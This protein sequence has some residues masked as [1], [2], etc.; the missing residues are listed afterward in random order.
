MPLNPGSPASSASIAGSIAV[1]FD[2]ATPS[3]AATFSG[4]IAA[5]PTSGSGSPLFD[6][7]ADAVRVLIS[8]SHAAASLQIKGI[9]ETIGVHL[10]STGGTIRIGDIPGS[11]A[12][13]F[14]PS[15]PAVAATF[16]GTLAA[17]PTTGSGDPIYEETGNWTR[18]LIAGS[19]SAA[20]LAINGTLT[21][22]TNSIAVVPFTG[23]GSTLYD[24]GADAMRVLISGSHSAASL[25]I[26]G[27]LT[28]ITNSIAI[29]M[30]STNGTMA[31]NVGKVD[32]TVAVFFSP[33]NPGVNI[34]SG[35][36]T[37]ITNSIAVHLLSTGGTLN[38][39]MADN[40]AGLATDDLAITPGTDVGFP[41][42]G[43]FD[44]TAT[45]SVD[46]GDAG[47]MRM[48]GNRLQMIH[49]DSTASIFTVAG[50]TS[51]VSVSGVQLVAPSANASFKVYA[52]SLMTTGL[53]SLVARFT[54][55]AGTS[56]TEFWRGLITPASTT[57]E[58]RGAN[59]STG[60]PGNPLFVTGVSTTLALL[61]DTSTLVHYSVSYTKE[62]A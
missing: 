32:G 20:S 33:A 27:S 39:R 62:S 45:D 4:S 34:T 48:T 1:Y 21:G 35:T 16:S 53:V 58:T 9:T 31:V 61:L 28:G 49:S 24:E 10:G 13:Y 42:M 60:G 5:V 36:V 19:Q 29:H 11:V 8:G 43:M 57:S 14:S 26:N 17:V 55:G 18:V 46:E 25:T 6:E 54:N 12:V 52:F 38:V 7:T 59:L 22:I 15:N 23:S 44:D 51:G 37:G 30:L 41:I 40:S 2:P 56:P 50:S 47:F 3:V